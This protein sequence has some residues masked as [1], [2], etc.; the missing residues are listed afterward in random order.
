MSARVVRS[1]LRSGLSITPSRITSEPG[2]IS[3]ATSGNAAE[4]GSAGTAIGCGDKFGLTGQRDA[5][6]VRAVQVRRADRRRKAPASFRCGRASLRLRT[7]R[8]RPAR[9][10]R[11][12]APR[13]S[14]GPKR[15]AARTRSGSVRARRRA[16]AAGGRR[17]TTAACAPIRSSGSSTRRIGR[18]RSEASPSNVAVIG[19]PATAPSISRQPVPELPKSRRAAGSAKPPTPTPCTLPFA[20]AAPLDPSAQRACGIARY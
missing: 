15:L 4:D 7:R 11:Q 9:K 14:T 12:A 5:A 13:I 2:V 10:V 16:S 1:P 3:A 19:Q 6:A 8:F 20:L 18:L 17:S